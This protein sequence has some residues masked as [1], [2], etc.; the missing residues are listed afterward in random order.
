MTDGLMDSFPVLLRQLLITLSKTLSNISASLTSS[1][2]TFKSPICC[3][4]TLIVPPPPPLCSR[5][6]VLSL[7]PHRRV[8]EPDGRA[9]HA[10][11]GPHGGQLQGPGVHPGGGGGQGAEPEG[12]GHHLSESRRPPQGGGAQLRFGWVNTRRL[13]HLCSLSPRNTERSKVRGQWMILK[14]D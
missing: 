9:V 11:D 13:V 3:V 7:R 12:E 4:T 2:R 10:A 5:G 8:E 14:V 6:R 1:S